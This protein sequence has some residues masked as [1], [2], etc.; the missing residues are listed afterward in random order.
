LTSGGKALLAELKPDRL[1]SLYRGA[2]AAL[3]DEAMPVD[4]FHRFAADLL[5]IKRQGYALNNQQS[6]DSVVACG[7]V[8]HEHGGGP[9]GAI[10]VSM[11]AA[12]YVPVRLPNLV[13]TLR[14]AAAGVERDIVELDLT[15]SG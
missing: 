7:V 12:R 14:L 15:G 6:E 11:P 8:V 1:E 4:E 2:T 13:R 10:S 3:A 9:A 5:L